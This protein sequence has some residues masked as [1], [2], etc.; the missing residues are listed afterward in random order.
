MN[1][2]GL[3]EIE[4]RRVGYDAAADAKLAAQFSISIQARRL[5]SREQDR[6]QPFASFAGPSYIPAT[7]GQGLKAG[8]SRF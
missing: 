7:G 8:N 1:H 6:A 5:R 3:R 4:H 2:N